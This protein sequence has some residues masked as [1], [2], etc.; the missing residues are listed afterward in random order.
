MSSQAWIM[1]M[2]KIILSTSRDIGS[3]TRARIHKFMQAHVCVGP[4]VSLAFC[5][6]IKTEA[7]I[8]GGKR[9]EATAV[10]CCRDIY[11]L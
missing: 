10:G 8:Q 6:L 5:Q 4:D 3:R 1:C 9:K 7:A 11:V 2:M